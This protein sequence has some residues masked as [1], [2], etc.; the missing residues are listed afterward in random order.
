MLVG[1]FRNA[2]SRATCFSPHCGPLASA[3]KSSCSLTRDCA[4]MDDLAD[5]SDILN[6]P[7]TQFGRVVVLT[8]VSLICKLTLNF[9]NRTTIHNAPAI[10]YMESR[11][12]GRALITVS[13]HT[14]CRPPPPHLVHQ[15]SAHVLYPT[16]RRVLSLAPLA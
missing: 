9:M 3:V 11:E 8:S 1:G 6:S 2:R 7:T 5:V 15:C 12:D 16:N 4:A 14:R 13:N 10:R